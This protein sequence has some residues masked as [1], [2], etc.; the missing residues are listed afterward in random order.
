MRRL[1]HVVTQ[2]NEPLAAE[3]IRLQRQRPDC[4]VEVVE[5]MPPD[6]DY[7]ALLERIFAVDSVQVW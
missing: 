4:E 7:E 6:L 1:L 3:I 2:V 5:L